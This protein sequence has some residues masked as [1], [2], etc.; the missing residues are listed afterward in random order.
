MRLAFLALLLFSSSAFAQSFAGV[1]L[2]PIVQARGPFKETV[3][4][5]SVISEAGAIEP[6][7]SATL[8]LPTGSSP[9]LGALFWWGST[10]DG[11]PDRQ[12]TVTL[13]DGTVLNLSADDP[14]PTDPTGSAQV[15]G[16]ATSTHPGVGD[17][18]DDSD[19]PC[20]TIDDIGDGT[21]DKFFQCSLDITTALA[22]LA[23]LNGAY[24]FGSLSPDVG[25]PFFVANTSCN[26]VGQACSIYVGGFALAL[27]Y[28]DPTD[29]DAHGLLKPRVI[30]LANGLVFTQQFGN[31]ASIALPPFKMTNNG[32]EV[33]VVAL[34]GDKEFPPAG[35]CNAA[36]PKNL[37]DTL[38]ASGLPVCDIFAFCDNTRS[39]GGGAATGGPGTCVSNPNTGV[40][41]L[42]KSD[43]VTTLA[44]AANPPGNIFNETV[45]DPHVSNVS[46]T[47]SIDI[48]TFPLQ[49]A[50][51][52][53][54]SVNCIPN[55]VH[56]N[57]VMGIQTG[58]DAVL[59]GVVAVTIEDTDSDGDGLSDIDETD[60]FGTDP[61]NPDT[62]GDG[63][64]DGVEVFGGNPADPNSNPTDPL[65]PDTDG[66]GLCDGSNSVAPCVDANNDGI[67][68]GPFKV[69]NHPCARGEDLNNDGIRQPTETDPNK[70]DT[71][72][73]GLTDGEEVL[74]GNYDSPC[75]LGHCVDAD[76]TRPGRQTDPLNPDTDGDGLLDGAEDLN[77]NGLFDA[78][79]GETD[80]TNPDTDSGGENDGSER[81]H[82]R[83]PTNNPADDNGLGDDDD[84]DGLTNGEEV[85]IG[86]DPENPDTD[87]DGLPDGVEVN[88][89]NKTDPL[90]PD[91]DGDGIPDG[92]ED[93]NHDGITEPGETDPLDPDSDRDGLCD[94]SKSIST[95]CTDSNGDGICDGPYPVKQR[96]CTA[97]ED[98]ND[99]GVVDSGETDP[100]N[101]DTDGD[102]L[103]DGSIV[104]PGST[105]IDG[106]VPH[107]TDPLN[108]DTDGDG[109]KDGTEVGSNYPGCA[110]GCVDADPSRPGF[111]T[112]PLKAD[113]DGD[114]I[115]DGLEDFNKNGTLESG[116]TD[117]T[118][119]NSP[120][121]AG[122]GEGEGEGAPDGGE[123]EPTLEKPTPEVDKLIAGSA[124]WACGSTS[125]ATS[126]VAALFLVLGLVS[127]SFAQRRRRGVQ[128]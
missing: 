126:P 33:T 71:D 81:Q 9:A 40:L 94:G 28:V 105:C 66:D 104:A 5:A 30:Q 70:A 48:D 113:S 99:N 67:C 62:D 52:C 4:G 26:P 56:S 25:P 111:Q 24:T 7:A 84:G 101:P 78:A 23:T 14:T 43:V 60:V 102:G 45:S 122:E 8:T 32:G 22:N 106:E 37:I 107:G 51:T 117:P 1:S 16:S 12:V 3:V 125:G 75:P 92:V 77:K 76:P 47:N 124:I 118:N 116:E 91:T 44:D 54:S 100:R 98:M 85:A 112:D 110:S 120:Q 82:G 86:T 19:D 89:V 121:H 58:G 13:P 2:A 15:P 114:G 34:E 18:T 27:I 64:P 74:H 41:Q 87:G 59:L 83:N 21:G 103:C 128:R 6:S 93:A 57:F 108:P 90:N 80:P 65:D 115:P 68:D 95:A 109:I 35:S 20:F 69:K 49:G 42:T 73:D 97:G 127:H 36:D 11:Q 55:G 96:V 53:S 17:L 61:N 63:I 46:E 31:D 39:P 29:V 72:N 79:N 50:A 123:G 10:A 38:D 88:G 119:P